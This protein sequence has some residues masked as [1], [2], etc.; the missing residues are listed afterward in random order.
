MMFIIRYIKINKFFKV[1]GCLALA[2]A[3]EFSL[4]GFL[5]IILKDGLYGF[6]F[7]FNFEDWSENAINGNVNMIVFLVL[8]I[9]TIIFTIWGIYSTIRKGM[10]KP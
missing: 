8:F 1:A 5:S 3:F 9:L 10:K 7:Q 2:S 4:Q 6:G